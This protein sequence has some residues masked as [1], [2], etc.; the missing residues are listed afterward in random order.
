[1]FFSILFFFVG[2]GL[3]IMSYCDSSKLLVCGVISPVCSLLSLNDTF[4]CYSGGGSVLLFFLLIIAVLIAIMI[5]IIIAGERKM[6]REKEAREAG[7]RAYAS[8]F[9]PGVRDLARRCEVSLNGAQALWPYLTITAQQTL[10]GYQDFAKAE[11]LVTKKRERQETRRI[12]GL[13]R[14]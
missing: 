3:E 6:K 11:R 7:E 9:P 14:K 10:S 1:M 12:Q 2:F 4:L 8:L 13:L 5:P